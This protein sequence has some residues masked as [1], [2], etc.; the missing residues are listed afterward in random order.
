MEHGRPGPEPAD[1]VKDDR[2]RADGVLGRVAGR[3]DVDALILR[4]ACRASEAALLGSGKVKPPLDTGGG[5]ARDGRREVATA[6]PRGLIRARRQRCLG[7]L[8]LGQL[9]LKMVHLG[10]GVG[11][12]AGLGGAEAGHY[13]PLAPQAG[14]RLRQ[15]VALGDHL[16]GQR[17]LADLEPAESRGLGGD[18]AAGGAHLGDDVDVLLADPLHERD[19]LE[20]VPEPGCAEHDGDDVGIVRLVA[21]HELLR[22]DL[23]GVRLVGLEP[24]ESDSRR[25]QLGLQPAQLGAFGIEI[26]LDAIQTAGE[27]GDAR[28]ELADPPRGRLDRPRKRGDVTLAGADLL[29]EPAD[30]R[31]TG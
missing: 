8:K 4:P 17:L 3:R 10:L 27:C 2:A 15:A 28:A 31:G 23:F 24:S 13:G 14:L 12:L 22:Q 7:R 1:A 19:A 9:L 29:L 20:Q 6:R 11:P 25:L 26:G 18:G 5:A 16:F 21:R 30:A